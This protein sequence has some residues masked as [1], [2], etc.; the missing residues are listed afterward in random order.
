MLPVAERKR[1]SAP[2][3][4]ILVV[5]TCETDVHKGA[6]H[7][8]LELEP[9]R[10]PGFRPLRKNQHTPSLLHERGE[11]FEGV[12]VGDAVDGVRVDESVER[13]VTDNNWKLLLLPLVDESRERVG[14]VRHDAARGKHRRAFAARV[15]ER[16]L[17]DLGL[18]RRGID[19]NVKRVEAV[20][21]RNLR[22]LERN[23][24]PVVCAARRPRHLERKRLDADF[25]GL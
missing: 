19:G 5:D 6:W 22:P 25:K 13:T 15:E 23:L 24:E 8:V 3:G 9:H 1:H 10:L 7:R 21:G 20:V 12:R 14:L 11:P 2:V 16:D 4:E 17:A 18:L